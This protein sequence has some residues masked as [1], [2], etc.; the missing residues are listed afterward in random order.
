MLKPL[1]AEQSQNEWRRRRKLHHAKAA[2]DALMRRYK[3]I[4]C[5]KKI[6]SPPALLNKLIH[7][8]EH[9][10]PRAASIVNTSLMST[11]LPIDEFNIM[12]LN[13]RRSQD[14]GSIQNLCSFRHDEQMNDK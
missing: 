3:K 11:K 14:C 7:S 8:K 9:K 2:S 4:G 1:L 10:I 5:T 13:A 12:S 6:Q